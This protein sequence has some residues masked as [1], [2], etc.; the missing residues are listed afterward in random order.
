MISKIQKTQ[1]DPWLLQL[2]M[3]SSLFQCD[4][5]RSIYAIQRGP[6]AHWNAQVGGLIGAV[7]TSV[8]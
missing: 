4:V 5:S 7:M 3:F 8:F 2:A 6:G 1:M